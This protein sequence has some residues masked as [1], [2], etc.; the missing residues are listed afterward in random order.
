MN[1]ENRIEVKPIG[2][3]EVDESQ[4]RY[5]LNIDP[6]YRPALQGLGSC[7]HAII[8]WWADQ[9][10]SYEGDLVVDLPYAPGARSGVFANRSQARP[11]PIAITTSFLINVDEEAG[12]VDLAWIDAFDGTPILDIKPYLPM[13]DRV[14][15]A[16]YPEWLQGF[17]ESM[18][19][20]ALFF[21]DPDYAAMFS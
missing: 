17:P 11:N 2:R 9:L 15:D 8:L 14:M 18:E 1:K 16:D 4:G 5:R 20:A 13:S 3:I 7:T 12:T 19:E 6:A 10:D 21:A